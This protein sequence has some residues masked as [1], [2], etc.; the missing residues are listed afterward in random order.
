[1]YTWSRAASQRRPPCRVR[2]LQ[3]RRDL[4]GVAHELGLAVAEEREQRGGPRDRRSAPCRRGARRASR[5]ASPRCRRG[6]AEH[7]LERRDGQISAARSMAACPIEHGGASP[8]RGRRARAPSSQPVE[9]P[10]SGGRRTA[11]FV[12]E[13]S[14]L[15][16]G[17][18]L[19]RGAGG[20]H[21]RRARSATR[22]GSSP[23][24]CA[25]T[26]RSTRRRGRRSTG[27]RA[28]RATGRAG[29]APPRLACRAFEPPEASAEPASRPS[30]ST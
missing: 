29:A 26:L 12:G 5:S 3:R 28:D 1:M 10:R 14:A 24:A 27:P 4:V 11:A 13:S 21:C 15:R 17:V 6:R 20:S 23:C 25:R 19:R 18:E 9:G 7:V 8:R 30:R 16:E 2:E 22:P